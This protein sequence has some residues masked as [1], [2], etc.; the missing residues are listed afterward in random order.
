[1]K[2]KNKIFIIVVL[3][4]SFI[5][6]AVL[7][8]SLKKYFEE[9]IPHLFILALFN[10]ILL[11]VLLYVI[12]RQ[13]V[14]GYLEWRRVREGA[15][16]R[17]RLLATFILLG[18]LPSSLLLI[19]A[20]IMVESSMET[21]FKMPVHNI[22]EAGQ[23]LVDELLD[24]LREQSIR[25][26]ISLERQLKQFPEELRLTFLKDYAQNGDVD[27]LCYLRADGQILL[28][29]PKNFL[30]MDTFKMKQ[31]FEEYGLRGYIVLGQRSYVVSSQKIGDE[32][33]IVVGLLIPENLLKEA[34]FI[35]ENQKIYLKARAQRR[36]FKISIFSSF[37]ALTLAVIFASIWIGTRL[38]KEI[39]IPL[40]MLLE[41]TEEVSKGNLSHRIE[42]EAKDE[43]GQVV[44]SF[45]QMVSELLKSR[46]A[47]EKSSEELKEAKIREEEKRRYVETLVESLNVG[48]ISLNNEGEIV[49]L[50]RKAREFLGLTLKDPIQKIYTLPTYRILKET[51]GE[52]LREEGQR[53]EVVISLK[54]EVKVVV[55]EVVP[56]KD[57]KNMSSGSILILEDITDLSRTQRIAAWREVA[58]RLA[59]EIKN[60]L[61]PIRLSA[62]RIRKKMREN[63]EDLAEAIYEGTT[64]IEREVETMM[65]MVNEFS[66]FARL[67]EIHL[68]YNNLID[69]I[70]KAVSTYQN[71]YPKVEFS[72]DYPSEPVYSYFDYEQLERAV[73]N[74]IENSIEAMKM[75]GRIDVKV[76]LLEK[77][78]LISI[79]DNGPGIPEDIR[80]K[81][82]LPY[83]S[84]KRKG[85]GLGLAIVARIIEEHKGRIE[86]DKE[87]KNGAKINI[88]LPR[89]PK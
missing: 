79:S 83:F 17:T 8:F 15:K 82:F 73:K 33:A 16:I 67:P 9:T 87:Y 86:V 25:K 19:G 52:L 22:N 81:M 88:Y 23:K 58:Q 4:L 34:R 29:E 20:M 11:M 35:S 18:I 61:T 45:N 12:F 24:L 32:Y 3:F 26:T 31:I 68:K 43:I 56:L 39:S 40:N 72:F 7:Y 46:L 84:T 41:G 62:Q 74:L 71:A 14:K 27:G 59:H 48:I 60:P 66:R 80:E 51:F 75:S 55:A 57:E 65:T 76:A 13:L 85:M 42:Y 89:E 28:I 21:W 44:S 30:R 69:L 47:L 70:T 1:M 38:T 53:K 10:V 78:V 63:S 36:V 54:D 5:V 64:T 49:N 50:N 37:L 6:T 77:S 2:K